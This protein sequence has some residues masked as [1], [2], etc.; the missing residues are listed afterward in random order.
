MPFQLVQLLLKQVLL[1]VCDPKVLQASLGVHVK[2]KSGKLERREILPQFGTLH[3]TPLH[4]ENSGIR[5]PE[6]FEPPYKPTPLHSTYLP[7]CSLEYD[8][9]GVF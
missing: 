6:L 5:V 4:N 7:V 1:S 3:Y 2:R 8:I 9:C